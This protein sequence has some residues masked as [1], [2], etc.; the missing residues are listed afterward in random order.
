MSEVTENS[1]ITVDIVSDVVCPWCIVGYRQLAAAL[2]KTGTSA[3][4][5]WHPFELNPDMPEAG[6]NLLAHMG[7]K[8]GY[9]PAECDENR[10]Q[11]ISAGQS[12]EFEFNYTE[13]SRMVNTFK[14][15]Q[16]LHWAG[17]KGD[18]HVLKLALFDA[19]F[20]DQQDINES[21]V[22]LR[23]IESLGLDQQEAKE[24]LDQGIYRDVVKERE[25]YWT[26]RGV[27]GVPAVVINKQYLFS[28]AQGVERYV[29]ILEQVQTLSGKQ[30]LADTR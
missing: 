14:A 3:E 19:Y 15:H 4:I 12:L 13:S 30:G 2:E 10:Q 25:Q 8:Y 16:L 28:G 20:T 21:S 5:S 1:E 29:S 6:Q 17:L 24:V 26:S 11:I 7:E 23:T 18:E 9:S 22:L 27:H